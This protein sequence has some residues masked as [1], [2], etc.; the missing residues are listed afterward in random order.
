MQLYDII[1]HLS[2]KEDVY[3]I[4]DA[5]LNKLWPP[6]SSQPK[7]PEFLQQWMRDIKACNRRK[8]V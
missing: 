6:I 4:Q 8:I 7:K 5:R 2:V 3:T 1:M